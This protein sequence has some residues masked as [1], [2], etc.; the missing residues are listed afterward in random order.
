MST[1]TRVKPGL[2]AKK[3]ARQRGRSVPK[4]E[5]SSFSHRTTGKDPIPPV[6]AS[7]VG[8]LKGKQISLESYRKH[9]REKS[10]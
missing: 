5:A 8:I 3:T 1:K 10:G 6:T 7:L 2:T 4:G 9:Q